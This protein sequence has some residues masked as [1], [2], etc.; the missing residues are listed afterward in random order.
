MTPSVHGVR[1]LSV[2]FAR[3]CAALGLVTYGGTGTGVQAYVEDMP[4]TPA[5]AVLIKTAPSFAR[6]YPNIPYRRP[7]LQ[8]VVRHPGVEGARSRPGY[9]LATDLLEAFDAV[10]GAVWAAS[11]QDETHV[12][13]CHAA[14]STPVPLGPDADHHPRWSVSFQMETLIQEVSPL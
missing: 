6:E 14:S 5:E 13:W 2:A 12:L 8:V 7:E 1:V 9:Q 10:Y 11:T 4:P 3:Q